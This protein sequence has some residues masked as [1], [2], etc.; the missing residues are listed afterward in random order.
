MQ[1]G[2]YYGLC[3]ARGP[4]NGRREVGSYSEADLDRN[5]WWLGSE[6]TNFVDKAR[7]TLEDSFCRTSQAAKGIYDSGS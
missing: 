1:Q 5:L 4:H 7:E 2:P 6:R 3:K